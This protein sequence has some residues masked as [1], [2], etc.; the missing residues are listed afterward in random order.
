MAL[1]LL[2][3]SLTRKA[4]RREATSHTLAHE[5]GLLLA[6]FKD[7]LEI[8]KAQE[9][10]AINDR[11]ELLTY[12]IMTE[13]QRSKSKRLM[14]KLESIVH[15]R[16]EVSCWGLEATMLTI[17]QSTEKKIMLKYKELMADVP[18]HAVALANAFFSVQL[19]SLG[20][21]SRWF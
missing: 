14:G 12:L 21:S 10:H 19:V 5:L 18:G 1:Y 16:L 8:V 20:R 7:K 11:R 2:R 6:D 9:W 17:H 4:K 15:A 13:T 3:V